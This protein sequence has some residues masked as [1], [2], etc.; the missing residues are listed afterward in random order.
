MWVPMSTRGKSKRG[1][2]SQAF[3]L[4]DAPELK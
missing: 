1:A 4:G 3:E 2:A